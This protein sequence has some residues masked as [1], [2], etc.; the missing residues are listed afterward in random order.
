MIAKRLPCK[1]SGAADR[2]EYRKLPELL[3]LA[4]QPT[5]P[6][7]WSRRAMPMGNGSKPNVITGPPRPLERRAFPAAVYAASAR[8]QFVA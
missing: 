5:D 2:G 1:L 4:Q 6:P 8:A 3:L 7:R